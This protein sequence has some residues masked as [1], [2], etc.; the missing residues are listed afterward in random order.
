MNENKLTLLQ[1]RFINQSVEISPLITFRIIFGLLMFY[2][3]LRFFQKNWVEKIYIEP[4]FFFKYYG[5][6]WV[7]HLSLNGIYALYSIVGITSILICIGLFYRLACIAFF[8]SFSYLQ[9]IDATNYLNHYYLV[10][11]LAFLLIFLPANRAFSIDTLLNPALKKTHIPA[12]TINILIL[13]L[14]IVYTCAG[15]AKLN[16][17]WL[18]RAMPMC[19]WLPEHTA[20]PIL[21]YFFQFKWVAYLFSW[22]GAFYDLTI[23]FFLMLKTT[24]LFAYC[25]VIIF[26]VMTSILFNIGLFPMIMMSCTLIFFDAKVHNRLLGLIGY[27]KKDTSIFNNSVNVKRFLQ[28]LLVCFI[29][30]Q[31]LLPFRHWLY[32]GNVL[33]TEEGYRFSWRVMLV[34]KSG[35]ATFKIKD[36]ISGR[37]TEADN[38]KY[39]TKFQEKQMSIQP[40]FI[41]QF[42]HFLEKEF[43]SKYQMKDPIIKVDARVALN[44]RLSKPFIDPSVDLTEIEDN[45]LPKKWILK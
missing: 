36:K 41:L 37:T 18:F 4:N 24:R 44:G 31:L 25:L 14:T 45:F 20:L 19:V 2:G 5:F 40:D 3:V 16:P 35:I 9:L 30:I 8:F 27:K 11:L 22:I 26:H 29:L 7:E 28:P 13:Q 39:L 42:A 33:W 38:R 21:G 23:A 34:E 6:E 1:H 43:K 10:C 32:P 17:D 12:W 15:I